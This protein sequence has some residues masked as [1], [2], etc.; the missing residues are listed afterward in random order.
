MIESIIQTL[1]SVPSIQAVVGENIALEKLPQACTY[2]AIVHQIVSSELVPM[3]C[4]PGNTYTSRVQINPLAPDMATINQL[5]ELIK[6]ALQTDAP[7]LVGQVKVIS[8]RQQGFG[9][10]NH[11][12]FTGMWTKPA[13]YILRHE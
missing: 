9:P 6:A 8:C 4:A 10:A 5:H 12:E 13:D 3:L 1:L 2:P 7:H 11:D